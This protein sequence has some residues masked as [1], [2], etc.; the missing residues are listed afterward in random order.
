MT[1]SANIHLFIKSKITC[2]N[3]QPTYY[4]PKDPLHNYQLDTYMIMYTRN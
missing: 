3:L 1:Y 4:L 2:Y